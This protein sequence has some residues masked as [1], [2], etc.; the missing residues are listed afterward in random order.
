MHSETLPLEKVYR[1]PPLVSACLLVFPFIGFLFIGFGLLTFLPSLNE[2]FEDSVGTTLV[3]IAFFAAM[4]YIYVAVKR[5][6]L[7]L[8]D[9]GITYYGWGFRIYTP[10][11]NVIGVGSVQPYPFPLNFRKIRGLQ[12]RQPS[13]LGMKLVEGRRQ[14][15]AALE[16]DWWNP[17]STMVSFAG[18]VPMISMLSGRNWKESE[19]G[20][21]LQRYV[22]WA[23]VE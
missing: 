17:A 7:V 5:T 1:I 21:D 12:L 8:T 10:W 2:S 19:V 20:R 16:T 13:V 11:Q 14:G 9:E 22:P 3:G 4:T 23:F 6:R 18:I 15:T